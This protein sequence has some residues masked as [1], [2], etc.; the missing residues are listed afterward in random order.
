MSAPSLTHRSRKKSLG[1]YFT[2]ERV[3]R[4]LAALADARSATRI[5]DPMVGSGDL[6]RSCL[7]VGADPAELVG[8][9]L[10][11]L[12]V[13]QA[14]A[15]LGGKAG[16][17]VYC[18][19]AFLGALP[20]GQFDL[21]ITNPPYIR[22]QERDKSHDVKTPDAAAVRE[23]LL[24]AIARRPTL[25]EGGRSA[26]IRAA[27][28][29][30]STADVAVPAWILS[31]A[32]V[33]EGGVLAVV[34][35]QT[36]W[37]RNYAQAVRD[38]LDEVFDVEFIIEDGDASWFDD[39]LVRTHLVVARRRIAG[40]SPRRRTVV[41]RATRD[42]DESGVLSGALQDE[43]SVAEALRRVTSSTPIEITKGLTARLEAGALLERASSGQAFVPAHIAAVL[44]ESV[45]ARATGSLAAL[46]WE[47]GQ[48]L[49]TGANEFFY[50]EVEG[51]RVVPAARWRREDVPI[52]ASCLLPV[53]R[54]QSD[55][56]GRQ[57]VCD[58]QMLPSRL[59]Y[60]RGWATASDVKRLGHGVAVQSLPESVS[61]WI[62]QVARTPLLE[63]RSSKLFP[64]LSAVAP[65]NRPG[66]DGRPSGFWY[67]LP[68]LAPRHRPEVF[69]ARV[70]GG[71]PTVY[72]NT[73]GAVVDANFATM[74]RRSSTALP[75]DA[76][77]ALLHS[78]WVAAVLEHS[79]T[80]LGGGALKVEA[81]DL[82][83]LPL[84]ELTREAQAE[85]ENL[86][87]DL[88]EANSERALDR[89]NE[90]VAFAL[91]TRAADA[92]SVAEQ[93]SAVARSALAERLA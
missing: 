78:D 70:C 21:V 50:V 46:G 18:A 22:Y 56:R 42:L 44:G 63:S 16:V 84:P 53:V 58:A 7:S 90:V 10:D 39:A 51:A 11:P 2:G 81:T 37:S 76:L 83:R 45:R 61:N 3:G 69:M 43:A 73:G 30:P 60:F 93:L 67:Q 79:C 4:L 59:A 38:L 33:R 49:R 25:D 27:K 19:D 65:N 23:G 47:V 40:E 92:A 5:I 52:P 82:R 75:P 34:V 91:S 36:W 26:M 14:S 9:D 86:G 32:L 20:E 71:R 89:V 12:A 55:V 15:S 6:L 62:E 41:G 48:G 85:L 66:R 68:E 64:E 29:Y 24:R 88:R 17:S 31:A 35:P 28:K 54:R 8:V 80:V 72:S 13:A 77:L 87:R 74:W 57:D 1:Q